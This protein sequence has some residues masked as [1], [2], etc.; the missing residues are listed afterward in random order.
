MRRMM[1][2]HD[3]A[4]YLNVSENI[5]AFEKSN[6]QGKHKEIEE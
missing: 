3:A 6:E 5:R 1:G 4:D 2:S